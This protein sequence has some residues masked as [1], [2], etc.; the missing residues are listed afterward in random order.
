MKV[1][2][3]EAIEEHDGLN[4]QTSKWNTNSE[5]TFEYEKK[6][7]NRFDFRNEAVINELYLFPEIRLNRHYLYMP[8]KVSRTDVTTNDKGEVTSTY[9]S[10]Y[11]YE[12]AYNSFGFVSSVMNVAPPNYKISYV[13]NK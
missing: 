11:N 6:F 10:S 12:Y 8:D 3:Q 1:A 5:S 7:P 2:R 13:Y 9:T 4:I